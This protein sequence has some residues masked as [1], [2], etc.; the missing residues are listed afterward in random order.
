MVVGSMGNEAVKIRQTGHLQQEPKRLPG[1]D[2]LRFGA[3]M[4]VVAYHYLYRG[5]LNAEYLTVSYGELSPWVSFA[6]FG[7]NLFFM[8]SGFVILWSAE[9]KGWIDFSIARFARLWPAYA[10]AVSLTALATYIYSAP[11]FSVS[12]SQWLAN[13]TFFSPAFG[14][15]FMDGVYWTI[16]MELIFY[17]W[18]ALAILTRLLPKHVELLSLAWMYLIAVNELWLQSEPLQLIGLTRYGPWFLIGVLSYRCWKQGADRYVLILLATAIALSFNAAMFEHIE[19]VQRY[20][21]EIRPQIPLLMNAVM[22]AA[23]ALTVRYGHRVKA[24]SF[25][26]AIGGLTYPL[27]LVHQNIGYMLIETTAPDIGRWSALALTIGAMLALSWLMMVVWERPVAKQ[28]KRLLTAV[29][30][31]LPNWKIFAQPA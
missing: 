14:Q 23:F 13:L 7:V 19:L 2:Y 31:K 26:I 16:V 22:I 27:Y 24:S 15:P 6:Y 29:T 12:L 4:M 20:D 17:F 5:N 11:P 30:R 1:L 3:A 28:I 9:N 21:G 25:A 18:I 8:I 10:L